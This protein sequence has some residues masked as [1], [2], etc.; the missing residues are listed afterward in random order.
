MKKTLLMLLC[1][2]FI[3]GSACLA[4]VPAA[5][6]APSPNL[7][8][9]AP[10]PIGKAPIPGTV[11]SVGPTAIAISTPTGVQSFVVT[12][13]TKVTIRGAKATIADI[14]VGDV[15]RINTKTV[16]G[17]VVAARVTIPKPTTKGKI[18]AIGDKSFTL[19]TKT[20]DMTVN[21]SD[22][23]K[24]T[25]HGKT[26]YQG[27]LADLRVKYGVNVE[28][29]ITDKTIAADWVE[30]SPAML[31]GAVTAIDGTTITVKGTKQNVIKAVASDKTVV[32][33]KVRTG[34]NKRGTLADVKA[35][36]PVNIGFTPDKSGT[37][38]LLWIEVLTGV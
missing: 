21:V 12:P 28:G 10:A 18:T 38:P 35:G 1:L 13:K 32:F 37:S 29:T 23:T 30:F 15:V 4:V 16:K 27:T 34:P 3:V 24:F 22:A 6:P 2:T 20:G 8:H 9:K 14:K 19:K 17:T 25:S 31:K 33:I 26:G 7:W 36:L 5:T 11:T